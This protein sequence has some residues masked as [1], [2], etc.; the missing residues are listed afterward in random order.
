M[1]TSCKENGKNVK[2]I[3]GKVVSIVAETELKEE[4]D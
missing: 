1:L 3:N 2:L 4:G